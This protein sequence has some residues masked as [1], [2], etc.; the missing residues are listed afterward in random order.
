MGDD[1]RR[2]G[3]RGPGDLGELFLPGVGKKLWIVL[4]V[5]LGWLVVIAFRPML[6]QGS[7]VAL[8]LLAIGGVLYMSGA[9]FY[10]RKKL[11]WFRAIWHGHVVAAAGVHWTAVLLGVV[12][13]THS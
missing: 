13:A 5:A 2:L 10:V 3:P 12:L 6:A 7:W 11:G 9:V 8:L 4:Y 1:R